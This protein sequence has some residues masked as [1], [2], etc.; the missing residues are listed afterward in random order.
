[1]AS[2]GISWIA[3]AND[4]YRRCFNRAHAGFQTVKLMADAITIS[5]MAQLCG[6][7]PHTLRYYERIGLMQS[8]GRGTDGHRRYSAQDVEWLAFITRLR[9]TGMPISRMLEFA[10]LRRAGDSSIPQR[11]ALLETHTDAVRARIDEL[12]S[13]LTVLQD[14]V[15]YYR[16]L[17]SEKSG[18][19]SSAGLRKTPGIPRQTKR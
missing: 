10:A 3:C 11:R 17:E 12:Q 9:T 18:K 2:A 8:V 16:D 7:T 4:F 14:K 15:A 13:C 19:S 1:M 5:K 6:L